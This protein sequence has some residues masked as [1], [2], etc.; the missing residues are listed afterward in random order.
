MLASLLDDATGSAASKRCKTSFAHWLQ[1]LAQILWH[2]RKSTLGS[3]H[4]QS[5]FGAHI[6]LTPIVSLK[7]PIRLSKRQRYKIGR[8]TKVY[9]EYLCCNYCPVWWRCKQACKDQGCGTEV[10]PIPVHFKWVW[11]CV[12]IVFWIQVNL[13]PILLCC[14]FFSLR[15]LMLP[16]V[17]AAL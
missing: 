9:S 6:I 3:T 13:F 7:H 15:S 14:R 4:T 16:T 5:W 17:L 10:E 12:Y 11:G 1:H 8:G 2:L